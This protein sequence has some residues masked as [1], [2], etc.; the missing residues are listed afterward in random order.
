MLKGFCVPAPD[1]LSKIH[2]TLQEDIE[3]HKDELR[4]W[5]RLFASTTLI[6]NEIRSR[7]REQFNFTLPRFDMLSQLDRCPDGLILGDISRRLMVTAGNVTAVCEKLIDDGYITRTASPSDRR[8]QIVR[9]TH[10]GRAAF[11]IMAD[12]HATWVTEFFGDLDATDLENLNRI[13][14]KLK[15]SA[16]AR[17]SKSR[18]GASERAEV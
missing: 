18:T 7:L 4:A 10:A 11:A 8:V 14:R 5:L 13:L 3:H 1:A 17:V 12:A 15:N 9:M 6:E 16:Q 2:T